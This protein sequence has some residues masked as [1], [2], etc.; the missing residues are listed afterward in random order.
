MC[1]FVWLVAHCMC[2]C[3]LADVS[4]CSYGCLLGGMIQM[5]QS[6]ITVKSFVGVLTYLR[7]CLYDC[8]FAGWTV[9]YTMCSNNVT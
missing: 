7:V 2:V 6:R 5:Q 1:L 8:R 3:K 4:V 9:C